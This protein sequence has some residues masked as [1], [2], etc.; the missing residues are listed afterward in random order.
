MFTKT[1]SIDESCHVQPRPTALMSVEDNFMPLSWHMPISKSPLRY[2]ICVRDENKSYEMLHKTKE[3]ALNFLDYD[4]IEAYDKSGRVHGTNKFELT[5]LSPKKAELIDT[6]L[7]EE[8]YMIYECKI[9]DIV[10]YGD[11]DV[12]ISEVLLIHNKKVEDVKSTLF[13]GRGFYETT[14]QSP[15]RVKRK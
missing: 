13:Q 9:I 14:S 1:K 10:N 6:T 12:F 7:I 4:Y 5:N 3:F 8:S 15:K 2:A 11:H